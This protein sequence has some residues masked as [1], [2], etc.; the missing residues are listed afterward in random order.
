MTYW[1]KWVSQVVL[2]VK[3]LPANAGTSAGSIPGSGRPLGEGNENP[4]QYSCLKI[5]WTEEPCGLQSMGSQRVGHDWSD[6][7]SIESN[8]SL[9]AQQVKNPLVMQKTQETWVWSLDW[10]DPLEEEMATQSSILACKIPRTEDSGGLQSMGLQGVRHDWEQARVTESKNIEQNC[11]R[12]GTEEPQ[13]RWSSVA[14]CRITTLSIHSHPT[15]TSRKSTSELH[16]C[17]IH[18]YL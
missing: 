11:G 16:M 8:A 1:V 17:L 12:W 9:L 4:L 13:I 7:A 10:E 15:T 5:P 2:V 14:R 6:L 3:N 18:I